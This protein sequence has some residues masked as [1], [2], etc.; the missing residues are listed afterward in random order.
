MKSL[1]K[2]LRDIGFLTIALTLALAANFAYGQWTNPPANPPA[3]NV[4]APINVGNT[5][6]TKTGNITAWR[7]KAGNQVWSPE[8]CDQTGNNCF[9]AS[10]V[11][12]SAGTQY[13]ECPARR[14]YTE[15]VPV[16]LHGAL[17]F[18]RDS[19]VS[20][21]IQCIDGNWVTVSREAD[22]GR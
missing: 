2:P 19:Q 1:I 11:A 20:E 7:Q 22:G 12:A 3:Q 18:G 8:Y 16:S 17:V 5:N 15:S 14:F 6:Q 9:Q 10:N 4:A 13:A 21:I